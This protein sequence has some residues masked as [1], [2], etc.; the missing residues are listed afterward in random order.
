MDQVLEQVV[1]MEGE[2]VELSLA[3]LGQV[4][5]GVGGDRLV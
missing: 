3:E 5:G 4:G 1:E 2:I